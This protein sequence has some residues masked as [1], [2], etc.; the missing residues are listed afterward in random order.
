MYIY[1]MY[2]VAFCNTVRVIVLLIIQYAFLVTSV[3]LFLAA[4]MMFF[5]LVEHPRCVGKTD[6]A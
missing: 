5:T 4:V 2:F 1:Y 3:P 6:Y